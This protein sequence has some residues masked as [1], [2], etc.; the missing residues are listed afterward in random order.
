MNWVS[1][2][3]GLILAA[4][5]I[6]PLVLLY[7]LKLR[8]RPL[9]I[10][11]TLLWKRSVEDLRAN[12][13]FQR[14]R[15]SLLLLLQL[16]ALV[17][18]A[19]AIMQPQ[20]QAGARRG[21]RTILLIDNSAS[22]TATDGPGG[23]TRL[24]EVLGMARQR[25]ETL[26]G[27][28]LFAGGGGETMIITFA[29]RAEVA[30][31]FTGSRPQLLAAIERVQPTHGPTRIAEALAL[32]RAYTT[33]VDP[34]SNR[35]V[36][37]PA[38]LE[39]F[40]DGRIADEVEQVLRGEE[41]IYHRVG[42]PDPDNVG[43]T[44][45]AI[46]RPYDRPGSVEV[47]VSLASH[48][49][50]EV[51]ADVQ[52]SVNTVARAIEEVTLGAAEADRATGVF[53]PARANVVF[54]PFEQ[55]EEAI[56]EVALL[57]RDHLAADDAARLV[58][59]PPRRLRVALAGQQ[60]L[61]MTLVLGEIPSVQEVARLNEADYQK[62][63]REGTLGQF[64]IVILDGWAPAQGLMPPARYLCLGALPP[65]EGLNPF[66]QE[67]GALVLDVRQDHPLFRYVDLGD[68]YVAKHTLLQP[69]DDVVVLASGS[70]GP[71]VLSVSRGPLQAIVL[72]FHPMDSSWPYNRSFPTFIVNAIEYL[73]HAGDPITAGSFAPGDALT[74]RLPSTA[75][76]LEL[77]LPDGSVEHP[78]PLDPTGFSW[79][80]AR[81]AGIY[82]LSWEESGGARSRRAFAVNLLDEV[83][84]DIR[85]AERIFA[86]E[87]DVRVAGAGGGQYMSLWPWAIGLC[88][89]V[90]M[91]EWWIY[92]RKAYV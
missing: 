35:P 10:A 36:G 88:L 41:L 66:G 7:F 50:A 9:P 71:L 55:P 74:T 48:N 51:T 54:A 30:C 68:L 85:P 4:V 60:S 27:R 20:I 76:D 6:P 23:R 11:C 78:R 49:R 45:I 31:R 62:H 16:A 69:A 8:R 56:I 63:A 65:L 28:G 92:H 53:V 47:F 91:L 46:E 15:R 18:L 19:L 82:G 61:P 38:T 17:L 42:S 83:E 84:G 79:G 52:L 73:G 21:G 89:T 24:E 3:A 80:P 58:V 90:V 22:M 2:P 44:G 87:R 75:T 5:V 12:T 25:V 57:R 14:L 26:H 34:D 39:L 43:V 33:N 37:E 81:L 70:R 77:L 72:P 13:P 86:R 67:E 40:S 59:P 1:I 29:G 32:G 64:D